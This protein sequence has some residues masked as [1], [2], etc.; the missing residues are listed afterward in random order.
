MSVESCACNLSFVP[1]DSLVH[2]I[3]TC[4]AAR[5]DQLTEV[6]LKDFCE[7]SF[8][9]QKLD[10]LSLL[11]GAAA[12]MQSCQVQ[13]LILNKP[14][15]VHCVHSSGYE[16]ASGTL[17]HSSANHTKGQGA[18]ETFSFCS[19]EQGCKLEVT[20]IQIHLLYVNLDIALLL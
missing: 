1:F 3:T 14:L 13:D 4:P 10:I 5:S 12:N 19:S 15:S 11:F 7:I 17:M 20:Q 6:T 18:S 9:Y 8:K 2:I 16:K